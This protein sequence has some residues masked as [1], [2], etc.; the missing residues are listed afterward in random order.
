VTPFNALGDCLGHEHSRISAGHGDKLPEDLFFAFSNKQ[1][2]S[3]SC[4][5]ARPESLGSPDFI[6]T[7]AW[8][9]MVDQAQDGRMD[10]PN[11]IQGQCRIEN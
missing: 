11:L 7:R 4:V 8:L 6:Q 2:A 3:F 9:D 1:S 5:K 10:L